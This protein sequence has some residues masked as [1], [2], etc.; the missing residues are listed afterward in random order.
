MY[1]IK[2]HDWSNIKVLQ[3]NRKE[4]RVSFV[5]YATKADAFEFQAAKSSRIINLNG[6]WSFK[7]F[8]SPLLITDE[9]IKEKGICN[10]DYDKISVP[11]NWQFAGYGKSVYTDEFYPF[12]LN[13]PFIPPQNETGVYKK[14]FIVTPAMLQNLSIRFE[15]VE[16]GYSLYINSQFVGYS[17]GSRMPAEFDITPYIIEGE[18]NICVVVYQYCDG[19]YLEDQ[20]MWWLGGIIRDVYLIERKNTYIENLILDPDFDLDTNSGI[21]NIT[22]TVF[23]NGKLD[24]EVFDEDNRIAKISS[25]KSDEKDTVK[26]E[27]ITSWNAENPKLYTVIATLQD[28]NKIV[29]VVAQK[30]GFRNI[31]LKDGTLL[32]NGQR[33]F[34]KGVNRHEYSCY[35]GRAITREETYS[36]LKLIKEAGMNAIRTSHYPNNPF[37]YEICDELGIYVID[38]CDLETHGFEIVGVPTR[39]CDDIDWQDAYL[40]RAHRMVSRDRNHA[41]II[42]WSLGNE[43]SYGVNFKAMYDY[44]KSSE[45]TRPVHYEG[46]NKCCCVDVS[47]SMYSTVGMLKELDTNVSPK[48]PHILC[49]FAHAMGN[50]P[51]SLKEYFEVCENSQRIQGLFVWEFKD[52]G[53]YHKRAD[54]SIEYKYGGEF[55]EKYHNGNFCMD[56]LVMSDGTPTPGFYEYAKVIE[57]VHILSFDKKNMSVDIKNRWDFKSLKNVNMECSVKKDGILTEKY[58]IEIPDILPHEIKT[59]SL[60]KHFNEFVENALITIDV[61]FILNED[62]KWCKKG[63]V[64]GKSNLVLKEYTPC[65]ISGLSPVCAEFINNKIIV[66]GDCFSFTI[67]L[68]DGRIHDYKYNEK[69]LIQKGPVLNYF[70]AFIDNDKKNEDDWKERHLHAM[71]MTIETANIQ[72]R[73]NCTEVILKGVF[74]PGAKNWKTNVIITYF[75]TDK[76]YVAINLKGEFEGD[77]GGGYYDE[78]PKIGTKSQLPIEFENVTYCGQGLNECYCD[79]REN[80]SK[81]IYSLNYRDLEVRYEFP[82]DN[83]NRTGVNWAILSNSENQGIAIGSLSPKDFSARDVED[84]DLYNSSHYCDIP[85]KNYIVLNY[86]MI[87]SGLGSGSCGPIHM[88]AYRAH[89][90]PFSFDVSIVPLNEENLISNGFKTLDYLSTLKI[91]ENRYELY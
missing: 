39:L 57:N 68:I 60:N 52:H 78:L 17:Q 61:E 47:S 22:P 33:I 13:P 43:S 15:G 3:R 89:T 77:F 75:I 5:P 82:Q 25:L 20:D 23:G 19:T 28:E 69:L 64:V 32:L 9:V 74:A 62:T 84:E 12:P 14:I 85:R 73:D 87:N 53:I 8:S 42:I 36:E 88:F 29:E 26:I 45:P 50:G 49:E 65:V 70:R 1:N 51:G 79:S 55:G 30:V 21:L 83:G 81:S 4:A 66:T 67:S 35:R 31:N 63:Y 86:D 11:M 90:I 24:I 72:K 27:G 44:I 16:S 76:G 59:V 71:H 40:D 18:N 2:N 34:M 56:G 54:G 80:T 6:E 48:R 10:N 46:D 37:F 58:L 7:W 41:C 38:E 91:K